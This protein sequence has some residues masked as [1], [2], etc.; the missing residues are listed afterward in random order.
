MEKPNP[1]S[2][3]WHDGVFFFTKVVK[4]IAKDFL[5]RNYSNGKLGCR[6]EFDI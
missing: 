4:M 6:N 2:F 3:T 5:M 1:L